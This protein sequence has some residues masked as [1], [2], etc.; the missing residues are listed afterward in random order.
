MGSKITVVLEM[1]DG[2]LFPMRQE[3]SGDE[4]KIYGA[5][6]VDRA[7]IHRIAGNYLGWGPIPPIPDW[8]WHHSWAPEDHPA[9]SMSLSSEEV[10]IA[11]HLI[12]EQRVTVVLEMNDGALFPVRS[13]RHGDRTFE[14]EEQT[15]IRCGG[16]PA[17]FGDGALSPRFQ[18]GFGTTPLGRNVP[19]YGQPAWGRIW[20]AV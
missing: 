7:N 19:R 20:R 15:K 14:I 3:I 2:S 4:V 16:L 17:A 6:T 12:K 18:I 1:K 10:G 9:N 13:R 5:E 8:T 11:R